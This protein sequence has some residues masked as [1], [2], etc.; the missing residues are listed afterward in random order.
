[1]TK[2]YCD[3]CNKEAGSFR[4]NDAAKLDNL[5]H[6]DITYYHN[7]IDT[8]TKEVDMCKS[9]Y[10]KIVDLTNAIMSVDKVFEDFEETDIGIEN[11]EEN[12]DKK[13]HGF[14]IRNNA[15]K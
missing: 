5:V 7:S 8:I 11:K 14:R 12:G 13:I 4:P 1:M 15:T 3:I 10:D 9:C 6:L 2:I